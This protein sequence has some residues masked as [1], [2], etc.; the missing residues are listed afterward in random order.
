M[1]VEPKVHKSTK[2][3]S[4]RARSTNRI[5]MASMG[6]EKPKKE[7]KNMIYLGSFNPTIED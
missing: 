6:V 3:I 5:S 1:P 2:F 7:E 4:A